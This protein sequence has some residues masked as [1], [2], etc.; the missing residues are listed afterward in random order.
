MPNVEMHSHS[1]NKGRA[2]IGQTELIYKSD[3]NSA[4]C[5]EGWSVRGC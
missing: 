2:V 3:S 4:H 1:R 5:L